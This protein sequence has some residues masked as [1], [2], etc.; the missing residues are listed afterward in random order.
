MQTVTELWLGLYPTIVISVLIMGG[1][2]VYFIYSFYRSKY[3]I[4]EL[5]FL[6][7]RI[8]KRD[9][10]SRKIVW[11]KN[12]VENKLVLKMQKGSQRNERKKLINCGTIEIKFLN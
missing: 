8:L 1:C 3:R 11:E 5:V 2:F 10:W 9:E 12:I 6:E 7:E 4:Q